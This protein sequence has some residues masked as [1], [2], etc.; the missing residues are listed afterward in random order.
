MSTREHQHPLEEPRKSA[1]A[2][3]SGYLNAICHQP[4]RLEVH[5][6]TALRLPASAGAR[7][8]R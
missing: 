5:T 4:D 7:L 1:M 6:N 3:I 8:C 2:S